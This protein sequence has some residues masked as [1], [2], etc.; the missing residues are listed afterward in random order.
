MSTV[1]SIDL[2]TVLFEA[3]LELYRSF[4]DSIIESKYITESSKQLEY[5]NESFKEAII[6]YVNKI[7]QNISKAWE[8][9]KTK[10]PKKP[11][12]DMINKNIKYLN[13]ETY[14]GMRFNNP[15]KN[16]ILINFN[17]WD[18]IK[19]GLDLNKTRLDSQ[20][21]N[22]MKEFLNSP[23]EFISHNYG[24]I[25]GISSNDDKVNIREAVQKRV[26]IPATAGMIITSKEIAPYKDFILNY[27]SEAD[28]IAEDVKAVNDSNKNIQSMLNS[29]LASSPAEAFIDANQLAN[30]LHEAPE[31]A[32]KS[33]NALVNVDKE[34]DKKKSGKDRQY[35]VNYYTAQT[36]VF[37]A[38]LATCNKILFTSFKLCRNFIKL[39]GGSDK[40]EN[41]TGEVKNIP[42]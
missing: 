38:K 33:N 21:Y 39:Q 28:Q 14:K 12:I 3:E 23:D 10:I 19:Q 36:K 24:A 16:A 42:T 5:I 17:A 2:D 4:C 20:S 27:Q 18:Q 22:S 9:F 41:T 6:N 37:S 7:A 1:S 35:I 30:I 29:V 32:P 26:F 34:D 11:M 15:D 13:N 40:Q 31:N 25:L 8:L